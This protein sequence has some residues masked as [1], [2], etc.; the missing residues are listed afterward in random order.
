MTIRWKYLA[1]LV[2]VAPLL[3]LGFAWSGLMSVKASTGHWGMTDWCWF[4]RGTEPV[5]PPRSEP[6]LSMVF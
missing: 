3:G 6:P 5:F 1:I 2:I 4:S